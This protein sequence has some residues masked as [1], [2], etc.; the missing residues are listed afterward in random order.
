[1]K[2]AKYNHNLRKNIYQ[3]STMMPILLGMLGLAGARSFERVKGK[4]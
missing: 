1:M 2:I 4:A 3:I